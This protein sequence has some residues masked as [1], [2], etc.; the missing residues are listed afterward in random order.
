MEMAQISAYLTF[1]GNCREAMT[2][3]KECFGGVLKFQTMDKLPLSEKMPEKMKN[4]ILHST[5][6]KDSLI[7]HGS[8]MVPQAGL[9]KGNSVSILVNCSTI[10]EAR[11][12]YQKLLAGGE[13]GSDLQDTFW[14]ALF[15]DVADKYGNHW[16][17]NHSEK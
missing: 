6:T 8:D 10:Q 13:S 15:G 2:F 1:N 4:C 12:I 17:I 9:V 5:L 16:L 7:L 11:K 3:Y 14:G